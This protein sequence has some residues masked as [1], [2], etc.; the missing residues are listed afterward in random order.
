MHDYALYADLYER[1]GDLAQAREHLNK[2]IEIF[3]ECGADG[4]V[5]KYEKELA[6]LS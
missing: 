5:E 3:K 4:W 6:P 1:K 2:A